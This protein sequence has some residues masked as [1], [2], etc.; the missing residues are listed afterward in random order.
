MDAVKHKVASDVRER[1]KSK[2]DVPGHMQTGP[3]HSRAHSGLAESIAVRYPACDGRRS[4]Y[5]GL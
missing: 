5:A 1:Q 3:E 4:G 2:G